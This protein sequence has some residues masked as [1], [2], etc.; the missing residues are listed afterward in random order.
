MP[1]KK[2]I[3]PYLVSK[4]TEKTIPIAMALVTYGMKKMVWKIFLKNLMEL[5]QIAMMSER[6]ME[7]GTVMK[8]KRSVF[9]R[10][11]SMTDSKAVPS[12]PFALWIGVK[13]SM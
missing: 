3:K 7:I 11:I 1:N 4:I 5:R 6:M 10:P 2:F 12:L 9:G 13:M 8:V